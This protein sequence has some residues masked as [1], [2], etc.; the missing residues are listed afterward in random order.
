[1][2]LYDP[3]TAANPVEM[4]RCFKLGTK[5]KW[6]S[7]ATILPCTTY[8]EFYEIMLRIE[9]SENMP[10]ESEE[11]EERGSNQ[12]KHDKNRGQSCQG[13]R[14][15][16]SFKKSGTSYSSS[17]GGFSAT[18]Q[19]RG[20]RFTEGPRF[21][22][23]KES[24]G[25]SAPL[26]RRC[27]NRYFGE[28]RR[29]SSDCYTCGQMRHLSKY[30]PQNPQRL[31]PPQ[32]PPLPPPVQTHQFSGSS[33]YVPT[34][35]SGAYHYPGISFLMLQGSISTLMILINRVVMASTRENTC[36]ISRVVWV[37]FQPTVHSGSR[38]DNPS[39]LML[40]LVVL[41][42]RDSIVRQVGGVMRR[43]KVFMLVEVED[44]DNRPRGIST[45]LP[46]RTPRTILI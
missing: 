8:Q 38:E 3:K 35:R 9:D 11:E 37:S 20:G 21:Q 39:K 44:D 32:Q 5:K 10:S 46:C 29:G 43:V 28:C 6:R 25:T 34:G 27:N 18:G 19:R 26:G 23:P 4:L 2:S 45:T 7:M 1:M 17:S 15:T 40:L 41:D 12:K 36:H 16:Q 24:A 22:K 42:R 13:P 33:G 30:C 14:Q 31:Q